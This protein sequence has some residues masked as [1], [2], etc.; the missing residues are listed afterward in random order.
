[1]L[2]RGSR[3]LILAVALLRALRASSDAQGITSPRQQF[4]FN[5][6]D[7]YQLAD[8]Q[9]VRRLLAQARRRVRPD[10]G[11]R[12][13]QDRGRAAPQLMAIITSP[14]NFKK[15]DRYKEIS[16]RLATAD[17]LTDEQARALAKEGKAVVWI[18][19]GLHAT[20]VLGAQQLIE[21]VYQ[22]VS[23]NDAE[24]LRFLNDWSSS[25]CTRIPTAWSSSRLVHARDAIRCSARTGS[26]R[27]STRS[28][29]GTTTTATST[30]R[31]CRRR[32]NMNQRA[33]PRVVPADH[34]QPSPD[35]AGRHGDVR[36]AVPRSVQLQLRSARPDRHRP[37]R[38]GDGQPLRRRRQAG[39]HEPQGI[40]L[41]D[42]VERR[43]ADDG[44]LP[45]HDRPADGDDRQPDAD[46]IP[47][48]PVEAA[49]ATRTCR[50]RSSRSDLALPP[51]DRLLDDRQL[52]GARR[53][54]AQQRARS[55]STSTRWGRTRSSAAAATLDRRR[56][57][58]SIAAASEP[59]GLQGAHHSSGHCCAIRQ[60]RD[61][62]GF[63]LPSNQPDFP[64]ATKFI[65]ALIKTGITVHRATAPF[66]RG[67]Q[68][69]SGR[70]V[71]RE[72]GA[73]VPAARAR[74]VRAAGS[75]GR[76]S[77]PG[78]SAD[79][80]RTTT[81]AGR[82]R[83]QMGVEFDRILDGFDGPFEK[84]SGLQSPAARK[85][86]GARRARWYVVQPCRQ[87]RVHRGESA[88]G[89][90]SRTSTLAIQD[91]GHEFHITG[92]DVAAEL[93]KLA[94]ELGRQ[95]RDCA[96]RQRQ[97][98]DAIKLRKLRIGLADQYGGS[99][100]SGWTRFLLE[101][102]EFPFEVRLSQRPSTPATC[103]ADS[104]C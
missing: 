61:P 18:D 81:P 97:R 6:G 82:S 85:V 87:Q 33:L 38:R 57:A 89:R 16:R 48:V 13:R 23:R 9:P 55:S 32:I 8:L 41:L 84:I 98:G 24:T 90:R 72:G 92:A 102:F 27:G 78:R 52:R 66:T 65:N 2:T 10:E 25:P 35:R 93:Q 101:Q 36:A 28:T 60:L 79:A 43:P 67:R 44:V 73:A 20:E 51:V 103:R 53:R 26:C 1:M 94:V 54:V 56:R 76:L 30:C 34:V 100:P 83:I 39:R 99:M 3:S 77:V 69:L 42:L 45:Q 15:L 19:G 70:L 11:R 29:P 104:T 96:G 17:G 47:F 58:G 37:R 12:D 64:T 59:I 95:L 62:R 7:D 68:V 80:A 14:E 5:I 74:H 91:G 40:D 46:A 50:S 22:L 88:A 71:R 63:I 31:T 21:T 4:G 75:S 49:A 86:T